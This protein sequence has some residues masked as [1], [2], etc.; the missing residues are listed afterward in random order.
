[1][2]IKLTF[3]ALAVNDYLLKNDP[4]G[5][6][7]RTDRA[8]RRDLAEGFQLVV[9]PYNPCVLQLFGQ[10]SSVM[11]T[12]DSFLRFASVAMPRWGTF[13]NAWSDSWVPHRRPAPLTRA[14]GA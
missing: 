1:L 10:N 13:S 5:T 6:L 11:L 2:K 8:D 12:H 14:S 9:T 3:S 4:G 7:V